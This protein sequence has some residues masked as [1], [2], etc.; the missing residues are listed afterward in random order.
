MNQRVI[1]F[2]WYPNLETR[3]RCVSFVVQWSGNLNKIQLAVSLYANTIKS[4]FFFVL[5]AYCLAYT[6]MV[7]DYWFKVVPH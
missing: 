4:G 6:F 3:E 2:D 1:I 5:N 7:F